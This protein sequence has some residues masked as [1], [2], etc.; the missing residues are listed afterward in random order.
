MLLA[1]LLI[2]L[3]AGVITLHEPMRVSGVLRGNPAGTILQPAPSFRGRALIVC[4]GEARIENLTIDGNRNDGEPR[5]PIAPWN[6]DFIGYYGANGLIAD[7]VSGLLVRAVTFRNIVNFA[8]IVARS[9]NVVFESVTIE[10]SGSRNSAGRNNTSGGIL[11]EEGTM[12]FQV[13]RSTFRRIRG[14]AVW[15]H[16]RSESPRN[17]PGLVEGNS[18]EDIGR[19]AIQAG[20]AT[21]IRVVRNTGRRIGYPEAIVDTEGGGVPVAIDTAGNVDE[22]V[23]EENRFEDLNGKCIDLDGF[24]HG[25]VRGNHCT[26]MTNFAVVFNN[27]NPEMQST[28][29]TVENNVFENMRYGGIFVV[30][31]DNTIRDNK[32]L[33]VNTAGCNNAPNC[34]FDVNQPDLLRSGIYLGHRAERPANARGNHVT[35]NLI[36]GRGMSRHCVVTSPE[37]QRDRQII[38]GNTCRESTAR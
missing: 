9:R 25:V 34:I 3:S 32:L 13:V 12:N 15:T 37:V 6:R 24:H 17:G 2:E 10:D 35:G 23:Y 16:S 31:H 1:L 8:A 29:V 11:L 38:K 19:D 36:T 26:G 7:G 21:Q 14:N 20:H 33:R 22:S 27:T 30:G 28:K 18:F 4:S 5:L